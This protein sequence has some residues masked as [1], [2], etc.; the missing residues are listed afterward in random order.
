MTKLRFFR[1]DICIYHADCLDGFT[2][3]WIVNKRW[4]GVEF[5]P[6]NYNGIVPD[7]GIGGKNILIVDFSFKPKVL[8]DMARKAAS[9]VVLDHHKTARE[10]L[11]GMPQLVRPEYET[12]MEFLDV[13]PI[14]VEFDMDR[15]GARM[16]W[17]FCYPGKSPPQLVLAVEDHDLWRFKRKDTGFLTTY[18]RSLPMHFDDWTQVA[19]AYESNPGALLDKAIAVQRYRDVCVEEFVRNASCRKFDGHR[20]VPVSFT[21]YSFT[22]TVCHELLKK[23]PQAPFSVGVIVSFDG[24]TC[25]LRSQDSRL[26]VSEVARTHGGGGHRNAAGFRLNSLEDLKCLMT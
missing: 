26:D 25:S 3:A 2:A 16:T 22:S 5:R 19:D 13:H 21:T 17:D 15:S 9:I 24:V 12:V 7:E 10:D 1:P 11:S 18:L 23:F 14:A 4:P 8:E 6:A 20:G